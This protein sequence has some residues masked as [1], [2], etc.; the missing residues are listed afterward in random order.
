VTQLRKG[1][2]LLS[3]LGESQERARM[4]L[5][6]QVDL[7]AALVAWKGSAAP[8]TG[9]AYARARVLCHQLGDKTA[10]VPVLSGHC[11][12]HYMRGNCLEAREIA[13]ELLR[14]GQPQNDA[15]CLLLGHRSV[16]LCLHQLGEF[17]SAVQ[18]FK[19]VISLYIPNLHQSGASIAAYDM[20]VGALAYIS[21]DLLILGFPDQALSQ[22]DQALALSRKLQ[23]PHT[24]ASA[25]TMWGCFNRL[26]HVE[27]ATEE[28]LRELIEVATEQEF[29][30][31]LAI[32]TMMRG[33]ALVARGETEKGL[34][35]ARKGL[36]DKTGMGSV[37]NQTYYL[38]LLARSC[39]RAG[40][41]DDALSV[42]ATA[43]D[44]AESM[45]ERWFEAELHRMS[46]EYVIELRKNEEARAEACFCRAVS[47]A[48]R[49][50]ARLWELR[51]S[52]SLARLWRDQ[53]KRTEARDLLAPIYG[54]FTEGFDTP[55]L[56]DAKALLDELA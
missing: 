52:T 19:S 43:L 40:R 2:E 20:R 41:I 28:P 50:N 12:F 47:V 55:D 32:A 29:S 1:L 37:A 4:E 6:L 26:R 35:L 44:A 36:D 56:K 39:A 38:G 30:F 33:H 14:L 22:I 21:W 9:K 5:E 18:N 45:G 10:L 53:G 51:A 24:L 3:S 25:L 31:F 49:Q 27:D 48:Q 8:D 15:A 16:A 46:G 23:H 11:H 42:L 54:W 7:C 17:A 34:A 13:E